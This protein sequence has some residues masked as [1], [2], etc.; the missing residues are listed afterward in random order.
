MIIFR[1]RGG[2]ITDVKT[3]IYIT[4]VICHFFGNKVGK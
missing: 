2:E 1:I 3:K 4:N